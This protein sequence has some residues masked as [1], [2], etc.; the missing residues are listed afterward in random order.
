MEVY[1]KEFQVGNIKIELSIQ[2]SHGVKR[3]VFTAKDDQDRRIWRTPILDNGEIKTYDS[4]EDAISDAEKKL[5]T[6]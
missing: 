2:E 5:G 6:V 3:V 4:Q 1:S